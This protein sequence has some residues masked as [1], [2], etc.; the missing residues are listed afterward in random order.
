MSTTPNSTPTLESRLIALL[1][2]LK[3]AEHAADGLNDD[4][5]FDVGILLYQARAAV[6]EVRDLLDAQPI[7]ARDA[8]PRSYADAGRTVFSYAA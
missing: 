7:T 8:E 2:D 4:L 5:A 3:A 6:Q 1:T